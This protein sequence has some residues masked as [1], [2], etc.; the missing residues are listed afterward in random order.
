MRIGFVTQWFPP[1]PGTVVITSIVDGLAQRGHEVHV[2]TGFPNYPSGKLHDDYP[3]RPYRREH[4]GPSITVHRSP[5]YPDHST[6]IAKRS[7]NYLSFAASA[8]YIARRRVPDVDAWLVYSSP[9]TAALPAFAAARRTRIPVYLLI[10]DLWPDSVL[11]A[12][13]ARDNVAVRTARSALD[14]YCTWTYRNARGL[15]VISEG[16]ADILVARGADRSSIVFTPNSIDESSLRSEDG[17]ALSV[18][19]SCGIPADRRLFLYAGNLGDMQHL[20]PV[21]LAFRQCPEAELL[22]VGDGVC[23]TGLEEL[24]RDAPNI[25]FAPPQPTNAIGRYLRAA[26]VHVVSLRDTPMLRATMPSKLQ[27]ALATGKPILAHAAGDVAALVESAGS[28]R[29]A[30]PGSVDDLAAAVHTL[31]AAS[32]TDLALMSER[33]RRCHVDRYSAESALDR[34]EHLLASAAVKVG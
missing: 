15:G 4:R 28:G 2:V 13:F 30:R 22:L 16:M 3:L 18:R 25:R 11:E 5:L 34:L 8:S 31:A 29:V 6:S 12:D 9:A 10:Q 17:S 19:D 27:V 21:V 1:E 32:P 23:R 33:A 26:D 20:E 7:L 14:R 24:G